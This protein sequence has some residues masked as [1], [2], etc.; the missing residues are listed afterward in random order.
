MMIK[1]RR[2][3]TSS[4]ILDFGSGRLRKLLAQQLVE[5][6]LPEEQ[7]IIWPPLIYAA[8]LAEWPIGAGFK[9]PLVS[10]VTHES[11]RTMCDPYSS[12]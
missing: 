7:P 10:V 9:T 5:L 1:P 3:A 2:A 11:R 12:K 8:W 4:D 6:R